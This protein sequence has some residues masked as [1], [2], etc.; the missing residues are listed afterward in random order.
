MFHIS[1]IANI[2]LISLYYFEKLIS[3]YVNS[4]LWTSFTLTFMHSREKERSVTRYVC[5]YYIYWSEEVLSGSQKENLVDSPRELLLKINIISWLMNKEKRKS[6]SMCFFVPF[7]MELSK[8]EREITD[9]KEYNVWLLLLKHAS[10]SFSSSILF[11]SRHLRSIAKIERVCCHNREKE[12]ERERLKLV[13]VTSSKESLTYFMWC[14]KQSATCHSIRFSFSL[15]INIYNQEEFQWSGQWYTPILSTF[16]HTITNI[17]FKVCTKC[18][19]AKNIL[20]ILK[21][22]DVRL[23]LHPFCCW[24]KKFHLICLKQL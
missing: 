1:A 18:P 16:I 10:I 7:T 14:G 15:I 12:R 19:K 2:V 20:Y 6:P 11:W 8:K 5:S 24:I 17:H 4:F 9:W 23:M 13:L 22:Y 21:Y 3:L